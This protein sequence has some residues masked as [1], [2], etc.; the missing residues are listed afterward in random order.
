MSLLAGSE[1]AMM[2][3]LGAGQR[4]RKAAISD[5]RQTLSANGGDVAQS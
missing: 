3:M 5:S 1:V 4:R 2:P